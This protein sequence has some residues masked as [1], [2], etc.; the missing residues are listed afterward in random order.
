MS[1]LVRMEIA[2]QTAYKMEAI[3]SYRWH[4]RMWDCFPDAPDAKRDFLTRIDELEGRFRLW[5]LSNQAPSRPAWCPA[6]NFVVKEFIP[7]FKQQQLL[8]FDLKANP[9]KCISKPGDQGTMPRHGKRVFVK[10]RIVVR[11]PRSGHR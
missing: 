6:D 8:R 3:D 1:W 2:A 7:S 5:L 11:H 10:I 4:Q 9:T